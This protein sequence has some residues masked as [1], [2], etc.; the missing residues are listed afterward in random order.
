ML[1]HKGTA[2]LRTERLE[3]RRLTTEDEKCG[4]I[5]E[6]LLRK[7]SRRKDGTFGDMRIYG[8]HNEEWKEKQRK[9]A[10]V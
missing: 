1:T 8:I 7:H 2:G 10:G 9:E 3:L 4:F 6:G 5:C